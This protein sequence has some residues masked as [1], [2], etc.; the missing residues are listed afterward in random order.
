MIEIAHKP[1]QMERLITGEE[2]AEMGDIGRCELVEGVLMM[3]SPTGWRHGR[4]EARFAYILQNFIEDNPIGEIFV[5]EVGIYTGRNPD[6]IRG[7]DALFISHKRLEQT[8]TR[9]FLNVAPEL[10]IEV[11][12]PDDRWSE[13]KQ[14]LREYFDIGVI[15]VWVADPADKTI[16]VYR[17][18]TKV[19][20][21]NEADDISGGEILPDF[22]AKVADFF[23]D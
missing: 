14:K 16:S 17:S 23:A 19:Q 11:M 2:L 21:L 6:T 13:V 9:S 18:L 7:A 10:I 22:I 3:R 8:T 15:Q 20:I 1:D 12:S 4:Y 5:G